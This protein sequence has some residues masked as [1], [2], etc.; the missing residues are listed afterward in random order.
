[1]M[2]VF[3]AGASGAIGS[4][5][6]PQLIDRGHQVVGTYNSPGN[7]ER[8]RALGA[9]PV[10][11]NLLDPRA[12]R[13]AVI[14][15]QPDAIVH[16]AT[17]LADVRFSRNLD[18]TFAQTNRLRT[19]GTDALLAAARDAGVR[20]FVAQSFASARYARVGGP[21]KTEDDPLDPTPLPS[22]R[23]TN[24]A[25]RYLDQAV[26][27]AGGIALRYGGFYGAA[28]DGLVEPVRKRFLPIVGNGEGV[29]S[30]IHLD[31][32]AAATVL[33]LEHGEPG[34]YNIVDD[35]PAPAREWLPVL[36]SVLGAKPPRHVPRWLARLIG[37][38]AAVMMGTESRGASNAKAK[39]ELSWTLRFPSWRQGFVAAYG[40]TAPADGRNPRPAPR[41]TGSPS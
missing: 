4:R 3:V 29:S 32:A 5:L 28:N 23:E 24:A 6:V 21:V 25:M 38:E 36:A 11:L 34:I 37:G 41:A 10:Q 39:R 33:A 26:T 31:D 16:Q 19:E 14:D 27:E 13:E 7:A 9:E 35:E 30:F 17:A 12:V 40:S 22:T 8:V 2:R 18:R 1:M 15:A 20:R